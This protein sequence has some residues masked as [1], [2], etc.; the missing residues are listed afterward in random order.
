MTALVRLKAYG[1]T[2]Q[3][4]AELRRR[5][6]ECCAICGRGDVELVVDHDHKSGQ[7]RGLLCGGCNRGLGSFR[8]EL[9]LV[10]RAA[11]Y[12]RIERPL[13]DRTTRIRKEKLA[14]SFEDAARALD[15]PLIAIRDLVLEGHL[16]VVRI[17]RAPRVIA[18][19]LQAWVDHM[20]TGPSNHPAARPGMGERNGT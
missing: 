13:P 19:S 16:R 6:A 12:L 3:D 8:D 2:A 1:L 10:E 20:A 5:Q 9:E 4:Y 11:A 17:G 14:M 15:M 18:A 7:V